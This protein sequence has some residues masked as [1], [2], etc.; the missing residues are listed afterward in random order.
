MNSVGCKEL[1]LRFRRVVSP[2]ESIIHQEQENENDRQPTINPSSL[3]ITEEA[4]QGEN[5]VEQQNPDKDVISS[6]SFPK[7][8]MIAKP[9][10][11]PNFD[12][13]GEIKNICVKIP[14]L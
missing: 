2:E 1:R 5:I 12:I 4:E 9:V 3:V 10:V 8:L 14:L 6:P 7:R 11:C 13:I